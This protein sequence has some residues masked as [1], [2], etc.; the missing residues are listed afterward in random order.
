MLWR[1]G[2]HKDKF[3]FPHCNIHVKQAGE[4]KCT[5]RKIKKNPRDEGDKKDMEKKKKKGEGERMR[6]SKT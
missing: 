2:C 6:K 5:K 1:W 4:N 3:E